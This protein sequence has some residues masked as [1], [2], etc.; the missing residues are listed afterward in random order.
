MEGADSPKMKRILTCALAALLALAVAGCGS[1]SG[2]SG[3]PKQVTVRAGESGQMQYSVKTLE[4]KV[5]QVLEVQ[6]ENV[7]PSQPHSLVIKELGVKSS[8]VQAGKSEVVTVRAAKEG[9]FQIYCDVPG[10]KDGGMEAQIRVT[11]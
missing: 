7:D 11:K 3:G 5:G 1:K 6:F 8:Q 10:H 9:T 2:G 4:A